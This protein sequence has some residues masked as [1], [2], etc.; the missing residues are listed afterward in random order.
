M[1]EFQQMECVTCILTVQS[2]LFVFSSPKD[3]CY[4]SDKCDF[5]RKSL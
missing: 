2:G 1:D 3:F 4:I 5:K